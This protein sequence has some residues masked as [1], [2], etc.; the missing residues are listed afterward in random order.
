LIS[1]SGLG[2]FCCEIS[3]NVGQFR[4]LST[5]NFV[6]VITAAMVLRS[7][8]TCEINGGLKFVGDKC[9]SD[10]ECYNGN[11]VDSVSCL[12]GRCFCTGSYIAQ[13]QW[14]A[15]KDQRMICVHAPFRNQQCESVCEK[16]YVCVGSNSSS[17]LDFKTCQCRPPF[18]D[19]DGLCLLE[20]KSDEVYENGECKK[21]CKND[22]SKSNKNVCQ[23]VGKLGQPC[24]DKNQCSTPFAVCHAGKCLCGAGFKSNAKADACDSAV[25][26]CPVGEPVRD[27]NGKTVQCKVIRKSTPLADKRFLPVNAPQLEDNCAR[28]QFCLLT[29][30][31]GYYGEDA[32]GHCCPKPKLTCPVGI[33]HHNATCGR[34]IPDADFSNTNA[35][36]CPYE[37]HACVYFKFGGGLE[38]S[39]C[40]PIDCSSQQ[41]LVDGKCLPKRNFGDNCEHGDQC[42]GHSGIC[43]RGS[44]TCGKEH[45]VEGSGEYRYCR[46]VC[47]PGEVQAGNDRCLPSLKLGQKCDPQFQNQCPLNAFCNEK[48]TCDCYCGYVKL[49]DDSCAPQ[50]F[51][52]RVEPVE[53]Q[54]TQFSIQ[55]KDFVLCQSGPKSP[56]GAARECP[57][58][59]YCSR[60]VDEFGLCCPK[61]TKPF[62][63][64]GA[65]PGANCGSL[66]V[67]QCGP[68]A[69]CNRYMLPAADDDTNGYV[70][71]PF[72][73]LN[74][75]QVFP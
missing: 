61:P 8:L 15:P 24:V 26:W 11:I 54:F 10:S 33:P 53:S 75:T 50:P 69:F 1:D 6:F 72:Q 68:S 13:L 42:K 25:H 35:P 39:L 66:E 45:S 56:P 2:Y 18:L 16:P 48:R 55:V 19:K 40:C 41:I 21:R 62:C 43:E 30:G 4:T 74:E 34:P 67:N 44:C 22:E 73:G 46:Q 59:Q 65:T 20:C 17:L 5:M 31:I 36:F 28:D 58:G 51:C 14:F 9:Q 52:P 70:C 27:G 12:G 7:A 49:D 63:P 64:N 37:T 32:V 38:Q 3:I 60:Y 57:S 29:S 71:C 23:K 47:K